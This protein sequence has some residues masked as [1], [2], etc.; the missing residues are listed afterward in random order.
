M[1]LRIAGVMSSAARRVD[2]AVG[3]HEIEVLRLRIGAHFLDERALQAGHLLV[4]A[5]GEVVLHLGALL[6]QVAGAVAQLLLGARALVGRHG[7]AVFL[8]L[9][10]LRL[11]GT[12]R[13]SRSRAASA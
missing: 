9:V 4:A 1:A 2:D 3:D 12:A 13:G 8:E 11:E 7:R 10:L 6:L 5:G